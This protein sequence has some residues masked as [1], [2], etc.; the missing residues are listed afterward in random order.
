MGRIVWLASVAALWAYPAAAQLQ[1]VHGFDANLLLGKVCI[2]TFDTGR[3]GALSKGA[4]VSRFTQQ[5]N[6]LT[7]DYASDFG[8]APFERANQW[9][10]DGAVSNTVVT[11]AS[12][13]VRDLRVE[14]TQITFWSPKGPY[15]A[16]QYGANGIFQG[17]VDPRTVHP[18]WVVAQVRGICRAGI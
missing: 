17:T 1:N 11:E 14:G 7:A 8:E 2:G 10:R 4:F 16:F 12:Q 6:I 5:T 3:G 15:F 13:P 18:D 9:M